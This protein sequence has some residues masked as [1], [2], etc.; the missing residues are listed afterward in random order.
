MPNSDSSSLRSIERTSIMRLFAIYEF[1]AGSCGLLPC[2][3]LV[4][5]LIGR[6]REIPVRRTRTNEKT[7][8]PPCFCV[9]ALYNV[10]T[11]YQVLQVLEQLCFDPEPKIAEKYVHRGLLS[12][13][14]C[15]RR[16]GCCTREHTSCPPISLANAPSHLMLAETAKAYRCCSHINSHNHV[17]GHRTGSCLE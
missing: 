2:I 6:G 9:R 1:N 17:R 4:P 7:R 3:Q 11:R 16:T 14:Q 10:C 13:L 5:V 15:C 8:E 12:L